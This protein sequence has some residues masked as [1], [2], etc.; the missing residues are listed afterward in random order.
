MA[1][2]RARTAS[3]PDIWSIIGGWLALV[4]GMVTVNLWAWNGWNAGDVWVIRGAIVT[5]ACLIMWL[6]G[7]GGRLL[8]VLKAWTRSGGLNVAVVTL[9]II[10]A[11][12]G[13]NYLFHRYHWQRDL[14]KNQR[15]TLS[16]RSAQ[17]LRGLKEPVTATAFVLGSGRNR[18][19]A[20]NL[21][22]QYRDSP[23]ASATSS[24]TP[25]SA[26]TSPARWGCRATRASCWSTRARSSRSPASARKS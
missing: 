7:Y 12:V 14:T 13:V 5:L 2:A 8:D 26:S 3:G 20:E 16:D 6:F 10:V 19:T 17:I 15:F 21:L 25:W 11:A 1:S 24:S 23:T 18:Q 9:G 22:R 4:F